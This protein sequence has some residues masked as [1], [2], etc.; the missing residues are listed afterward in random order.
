M[1]FLLIVLFFPLI[2]DG[3]RKVFALQTEKTSQENKISIEF[4][5][6]LFKRGEAC[7]LANIKR[8]VGRRSLSFFSA[9]FRVKFSNL[10]LL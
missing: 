5:H 6:P 9:G 3:F 7:L 4:Q 1:A 10:K 8:K 2:L